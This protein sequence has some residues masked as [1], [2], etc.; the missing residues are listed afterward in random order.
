MKEGGG[1]KAP[2]GEVWVQ[3]EHSGVIALKG[4]KGKGGRR[5]VGGSGGG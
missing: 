2:C 4:Q 1:C 5:E 3:V